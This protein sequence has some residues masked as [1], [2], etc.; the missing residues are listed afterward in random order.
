M[1][2]N[3]LKIWIFSA[4]FIAVGFSTFA[5][6]NVGEIIINTG[7]VE[8]SDTVDFGNVATGEQVMKKMTIKNK[9]KRTVEFTEMKAPTGYMVSISKKELKPNAKTTLIIGFAANWIEEE[10][11]FK[12]VI[13]LKSKVLSDIIVPVKGTYPQKGR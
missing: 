8:I 3:I 9:S 5:Q 4:L 10:G 12:D 6:E 7:N 1:K 13:I 11:D 2:N